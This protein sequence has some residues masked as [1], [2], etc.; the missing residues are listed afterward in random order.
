[1]PQPGRVQTRPACRRAKGSVDRPPRDSPFGEDWGCDERNRCQVCAVNWRRTSARLRTSL[2]ALLFVVPAL[3]PLDASAAPCS[4]SN[5]EQIFIGAATTSGVFVTRL[6]V[7]NRITAKNRDLDTACP[8]DNGA[9]SGGRA[10]TTAH[11]ASGSSGS[12]SCKQVEMVQRK[13]GRRATRHLKMLPRRTGGFSPRSRSSAAKLL[14]SPTR[15]PHTCSRILTTF[16]G[17]RGFLNPTALLL[18]F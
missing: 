3:M 5:N 1:M 14:I 11:I 4:S 13:F 6:G 7:I 15:P 10:V 18:G 12:A 2:L 9:H 16:G 8:P 17:F